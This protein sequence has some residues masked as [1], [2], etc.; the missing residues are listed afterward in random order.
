MKRDVV[1]NSPL[2]FAKIGACL[3]CLFSIV[4]LT[5]EKENE[6]SGMYDDFNVNNTGMLK[7]Q[8]QHTV[9]ALRSETQAKLWPLGT[10][11]PLLSTSTLEREPILAP[12]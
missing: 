12:Q 9:Q 6:K 2:W 8:F 3:S 7:D 4:N 11:R 10:A 1:L 5:L